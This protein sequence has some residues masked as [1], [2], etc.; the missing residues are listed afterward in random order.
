LDVEFEN[1]C[2]SRPVRVA[3]PQQVQQPQQQQQQG[4]LQVEPSVDFELDVKV[5][6][7][8]GRCVLHPKEPKDDNNSTTT[9]TS[10]G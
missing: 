1:A 5:D 6:I 9:E 10:R 2:C 8:S 3:S 7:D 4:Q